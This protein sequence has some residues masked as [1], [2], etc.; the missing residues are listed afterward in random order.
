VPPGLTS[1]APSL[2]CPRGPAQEILDKGQLYVDQVRN[3]DH[4]SVV[5]VLLHGTR[6]RAP[7]AGRRR[8]RGRAG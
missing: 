1:A 3:S 8:R 4:V 6:G 7:A 5:S 2:L